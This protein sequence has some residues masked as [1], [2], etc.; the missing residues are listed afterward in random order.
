MTLSLM[1]MLISLASASF[2][3]LGE[4]K[5]GDTVNL[6][7]L[8]DN[9]TYNNISSIVYP[10]GS[11][12]VSNV[13]MTADGP[14]FNYTYVVP[15]TA[16]K[17]YVNGYGDD[18]GNNDIWSYEFDVTSTGTT[19]DTP[20][21][22]MY[23]GLLSVVVC[24]FLLSMWGTFIINPKDERNSDGDVVDLNPLKKLRVVLYGVD[25]ALFMAIMFI[26]SNIAHAYS[27]DSL[28]SD[29]FFAI[30]KVMYSLLLP[31]TIVW[32]ILIFLTIFKDRE[33]KAMLQ[34]GIGEGI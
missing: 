23:I 6:I 27:P 30:F 12:A 8:C 5:I 9:C 14:Q 29:F 19:L 1:L 22:I 3:S 28:M 26:S 13:E 20:T 10:N 2:V 24:L 33:T 11:I 15:D 34:R 7:Q 32:L 16:G 18:T 21:S 31:L 4:F 25:Y 17:Y